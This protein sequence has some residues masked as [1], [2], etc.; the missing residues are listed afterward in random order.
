[1]VLLLHGLDQEVQE[2]IPELM[3]PVVLVHL[4]ME[5]VLP[6]RQEVLEMQHITNLPLMVV[7]DKVVL[8]V[9]PMLM[10]AVAVVDIMAVEVV[11]PVKVAEVPVGLQVLLQHIPQD[12]DL[13]MDILIFLIR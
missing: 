6:N 8:P 11:M 1:V 2:E 4:M 10:G 12:P 9:L 13:V 5:V 3:E 7:R